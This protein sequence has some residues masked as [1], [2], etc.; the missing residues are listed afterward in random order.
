MPEVK[1]PEEVEQ[2]EGKGQTGEQNVQQVE[3]GEKDEKVEYLS[4][5]RVGTAMNIS[6]GKFFASPEGQGNFGR[7]EN[8]VEGVKEINMIDVMTDT[9]YITIKDPNISLYELK[10]Q[11]PNAKFSYHIVCRNADGTTTVLGWLTEE[12]F[13]QNKDQEVQE[14]QAI[15]NAVDLDFEE[16]R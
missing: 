12:S 5:I 2:N 10:Q 11:Y 15:Q 7:F 9:Q 16:E 14:E 4:S 13:E 8:Y 3:E 1:A 6:S